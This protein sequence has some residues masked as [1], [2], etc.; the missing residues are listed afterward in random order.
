[1]GAHHRDKRRIDPAVVDDD[2]SQLAA[3]PLRT[4]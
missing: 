3:Q 4:P 1:M 2:L